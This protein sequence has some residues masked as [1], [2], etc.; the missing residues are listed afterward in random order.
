MK[1]SVPEL[2]G[3]D[4]DDESLDSRASQGDDDDEFEEEEGP[5]GV[6]DELDDAA[7]SHGSGG[8]EVDFIEDE[9]DIISD[10]GD[11]NGLIV[12]PSGSSDGGSA[13]EWHGFGSDTKT[14]KRGRDKEPSG[15]KKKKI[16]LATFAS[17]EDYAEMIEKGQE[18]NV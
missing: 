7:E 5:V 13:D 9:D 1:K 15:G 8:S 14:R 4:L 2:G 11:L 17:Y 10:G 12:Y 18:D 3:S 6:D 16:K